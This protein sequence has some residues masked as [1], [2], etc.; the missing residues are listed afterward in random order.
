[1]NP[2][3]LH[4]LYLSGIGGFDGAAEAAAGGEFANDGGGDGFTGFDNIGQY[5]VDRVFIEDPEIAVSMNIDLERFEFQAML[6]RD[7]R[8]FDG[9]KI[10]QAGLGTNGRVFGNFNGNLVSRKLVWPCFQS[11]KLGG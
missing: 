11:R 9:S 4:S 8:Q 6:I 7:V 1:M 10:W 2:R 3:G 5:F